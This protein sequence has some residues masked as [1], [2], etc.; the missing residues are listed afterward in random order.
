M[1]K[2]IGSYYR[3]NL[4]EDI[5]I[6]MAP[7]V[8]AYSG[9]LDSSF[10]LWVCSRA[11]DLQ[12]LQAVT[13]YSATTPVREIQDAQTIASWLNVK[14]NIYPGPE[15]KNENFLANDLL[16]CYY[17]KRERFAFLLSLQ[18]EYS[19]ARFIEGSVVDDLKDF[20]PGMRA[21]KEAGIASP[22]LQA[23]ISKADIS[24]IAQDYNL[25]FEGKKTESCLATRIKTG[26]R[27][28]ASILKQVQSAEEAIY[29]MGFELVRV[30]WHDGEARLEVTPGDI[31]RALILRREIIRT[32]KEIGFSCVSID[33]EGYIMGE[34]RI[35]LNE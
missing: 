32:V 4:L 9:G 25:P 27:I 31:Q 15:M 3:L 28:Q 16:R 12:Q 14:H 11:L 2:K 35:D 1:P 10:L 29:E 17:C 26:H 33:L 8:V 13:F 30:R 18:A 5:I 6:A 19:G 23:G 34:K 21:L 7:V 24:I 20:R 22:L